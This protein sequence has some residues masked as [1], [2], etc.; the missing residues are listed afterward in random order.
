MSAGSRPPSGF[1]RQRR[2]DRTLSSIPTRCG[3]SCARRA[4]GRRRRHRGRPRAR[5]ADARVAA[6]GRTGHRRRDRSGARRCAGEDSRGAVAVTGRPARGRRDRCDGPRAAP[7][8]SPDGA[9]REPSLQ[10]LGAGS[11][12]A[13]RD[14]A[15]AA[16][17]SGD[18][19]GRGGR[20]A[21]RRTGIA[22]L[23]RAVGEGGVVGRVA[24]GRIGAA[25]RLLAGAERRLRPGGVHSPRAAGDRWRRGRRCSRSSTPRSPSG[26]R[27]CGP[28]WPAGPGRLRRRR[29]RCDARRSTPAFE[30]SSSTWTPSLASP[31]PTPGDPSNAG[32][33]AGWTET[34]QQCGI[35]C[36]HRC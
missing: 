31:A 14:D 7:G 20:P 27:R 28:R 35:V 18:G 23:R 34:P 16:Q 21:V 30:A 12:A 26:A 17:W 32:G 1:A 6:C 19:A 22:H 36:Q 3:E 5:I 2:W 10:R 11:P 25:H 29:R 4:R 24:A 15:V 13:A 9:G 8:T 33:S